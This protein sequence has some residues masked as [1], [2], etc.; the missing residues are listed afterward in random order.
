M[1]GR[2]I[3]IT[4]GSRGLGRQ[5]VERLATDNQVIALSRSGSG[6]EA[7][8][9]VN[10]ACDLANNAALAR[11]V[12]ALCR[13]WPE[14]DVLINNAAVLQSRPIALMSD[15]DIAA[16][17][18]TNLVAPMLLTKR[19]LK[20]MMRRRRGR[21]VNIVSMSA[22]LCKPGDSV[23]AATKAGLE[24]FGKIANVE[25][26]PYHVTVNNLAISASRSGM[27]E[28]ITDKDPERIRALIPHG[29]LADIDGIM[30]TL[31]FFCSDHSGDVGGQTVFL[32]GV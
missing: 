22:K 26:H 1:Q 32:G 4:G 19:L 20:V 10:I 18:A 31:D 30:A 11:E 9:V 3:L 25:A 28:Q 15:A 2:T 24:I 12:D 23:Y 6:F 27:L 5:I 21:I 13:R 14:L 17:V 7:T 8:N 16:Q 29:H